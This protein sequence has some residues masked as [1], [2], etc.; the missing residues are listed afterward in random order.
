MYINEG[1]R[2]RLVAKELLYGEKVSTV[3]IKMCPKS[4]TERMTGKLLL[5]TELFLV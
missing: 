2:K 4:V 3:L 1:G 5:P